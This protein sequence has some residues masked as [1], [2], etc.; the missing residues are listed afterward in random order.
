MKLRS[1]ETKG[2]ICM[3]SPSTGPRKE[4]AVFLWV[5]GWEFSRP[6]GEPGERWWSGVILN[7]TTT[8]EA[9]SS[10]LGV[11]LWAPL[12]VG[13]MRLPPGNPKAPAKSQL[14]S[15]LCLGHQIPGVEP[16][17][18]T[19]LSPWTPCLLTYTCIHPQGRVMPNKCECARQE[20]KTHSVDWGPF[21]TKVSELTQAWAGQGRSSSKLD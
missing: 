17:M 11:R 3:D 12:V 7:V 16:W 8:K 9:N 15:P 2:P 6:T 18:A 4:E 5:Q 19:A 21:S 1:M 10:S 20:G 14:W 13:E